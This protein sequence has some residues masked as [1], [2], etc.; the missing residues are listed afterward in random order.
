[1][2]SFEHAFL[3]LLLTTLDQW[4]QLKQELSTCA[5][6]EDAG[7]KV[8]MFLQ[9]DV[10]EKQALLERTFALALAQ[11]KPPLLGTE[12]G[13]ACR[14]LFEPDQTTH[15]EGDEELNDWRGNSTCALLVRKVAETHEPHGGL[16]WSDDLDRR[17][18]PTVADWR[19]IET[20]QTGKDYERAS[21]S[22]TTLEQVAN[23]CDVIQMHERPSTARPHRA[24]SGLLFPL[25]GRTATHAVLFRIALVGLLDHLSAALYPLGDHEAEWKLASLSHITD[26]RASQ[27]LGLPSTSHHSSISHLALAG[28]LADVVGVE[29]AVACIIALDERG[30]VTGLEPT[31]VG[32]PNGGEENEWQWHCEECRDFHSDSQSMPGL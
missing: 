32:L 29:L 2:P 30:T 11:L 25:L 26:A 27:S 17:G 28:L 6:S 18:Y 10:P 20:L 15:T 16:A 5:S 13:I 14:L 12:V 21:L 22:N 4:P 23:F 8:V 24:M 9:Y 31:H 3:R 7:R 19:K 1:M